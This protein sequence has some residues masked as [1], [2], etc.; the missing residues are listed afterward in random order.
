MSSTLLLPPPANS[1]V[2]GPA[3]INTHTVIGPA[4]TVINTH[5]AVTNLNTHIN[6]PGPRS[7]FFGNPD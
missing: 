5:T 3:V 1:F 4:V 7:G 2:I 6:T